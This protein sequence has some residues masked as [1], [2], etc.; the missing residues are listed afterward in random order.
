M[1]PRWLNWRRPETRT[2]SPAFSTGAPSPGARP[3]R[4]VQRR[5]R[6][7]RAHDRGPLH[8]QPEQGSAVASHQR[9]RPGLPRRRV[10]VRLRGLLPRLEL[11]PSGRARRTSW[12]RRA[13]STSASTSAPTNARIATA[14]AATISFC[15]TS[16]AC[17]SSGAGEINDAYVA[18]KQADLARATL[19][20]PT[21]P[22]RR[23]IWAS[24]W[25]DLA[26][27]SAS[28]TRRAPSP[29]PTVWIPMTCAEPPA[30]RWW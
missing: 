5:L 11:P 14:P 26:G 8:P 21:P 22:R 12:W 6:T 13:A 4:R 30:L 9:P 1:R 2:T 28:T 16:A 24:G 25:S 19:G 7:R 18:Y 17:S 20:R 10:R 27:A 3:I 23:P 15:A 29:R